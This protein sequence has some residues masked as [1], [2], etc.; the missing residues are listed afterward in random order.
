MFRFLSIENAKM[1]HF[2]SI[3]IDEKF[4][5]FDI[6]PFFSLTATSAIISIF[7]DFLK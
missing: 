7:P 2:L 3:K 5:F 4:H 1:F 6:D